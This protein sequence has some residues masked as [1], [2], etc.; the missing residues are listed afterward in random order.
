MEIIIPAII[1]ISLL[2]L[3]TFTVSEQILSSQEATARSW[4]EMQGRLEERTRTD[5]STSGARASLCFDGRDIVEVT[6]E[7]VGDVKLADFDEWDVILRYETAAGAHADW[8]PYVENGGQL[9]TSS[10]PIGSGNQWTNDIDD[11]YEPDILN[12]GEEMIVQVLTSPLMSSPSTNTLTIGTPTGI[13]A[14]TVFTK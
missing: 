6:V 10:C 2:M 11:S 14:T 8:Y 5:L 13:T 3:T 1:V 7:N 9:F 4:Q 12:P